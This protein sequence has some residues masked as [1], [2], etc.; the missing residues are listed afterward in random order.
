[1]HCNGSQAAAGVY[2]SGIPRHW[3][4]ARLIGE[5]RVPWRFLAFPFRASVSGRLKRGFA[6]SFAENANPRARR[7]NPAQCI[8]P[9]DKPAAAA[10]HN[11]NGV[12]WSAVSPRTTYHSYTCQTVD[13]ENVTL[14]HGR[15]LRKLIRAGAAST[16]GE[17]RAVAEQDP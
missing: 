5:P 13:S 3:Q 12:D 16:S 6:Q 7:V 8:S 17:F 15:L 10:G 11:E 2:T 9:V 1:M 4:S 14:A